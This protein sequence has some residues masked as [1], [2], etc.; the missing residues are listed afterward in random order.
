MDE[1]EQDTSG[2]IPVLGVAEVSV[3]IVFHVIIQSPHLTVLLPSFWVLNDSYYKKN[4]K[5]FMI[6]KHI[7]RLTILEL[8]YRLDNNNRINR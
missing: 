3:H 4:F 7:Q 1:V 5:M 8:F 2:F 6:T